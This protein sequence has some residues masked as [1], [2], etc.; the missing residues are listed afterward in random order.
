VSAPDTDEPVSKV[1]LSCDLTGSTNFKQLPPRAGEPPWQKVFLQF[2]REF[3]Q[4]FADITQTDTTVA[5]LDFV[6][7][8]PVGDELIYSCSV[9]SEAD[10]FN[11][12]RAW[13]TAIRRYHKDN[14]KDTPMGTKGGAFLATFPGPDSRSSIPRLPR[15]ENSDGDVV[16]RNTAA[17]NPRD[18]TKYLYDYFGPSIDTGFRILTKCSERYFTLS[19]EVALAMLSAHR[20]IDA[21]RFNSKDLR[22][23]EFVELKGVWG[24]RRYPIVAIDFE[25]EDKVHRAYRKFESA[26]GVNDLHDLSKECYR[27]KGWPS[28]MYLPD[29]E[30]RVFQEVP[31]DPFENY[32][33][34]GAEG[35][36]QLPDQPDEGEPLRDDPPLS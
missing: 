8:K 26:G 3:P 19:V 32:I 2:Y 36:E 31:A 10:V 30:Q 12:V 33:P 16:S 24:G 17:H 27:S 11:A 25:H 21:D 23:L 28:K 13:T 5:Q 6:L 1:F 18:D 15:Y 22:L 4:Q 35:A 20:N 9:R 7:W 29:A 14:L 34:S